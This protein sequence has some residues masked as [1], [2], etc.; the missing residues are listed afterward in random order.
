MADAARLATAPDIPIIPAGTAIKEA[1]KD[2]RL[3]PPPPPVRVTSMAQACMTLFLSVYV[4]CPVNLPLF[5]LRV[6]VN[7]VLVIVS[8]TGRVTELPVE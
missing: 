3:A 4:P 2:P 7:E 5:S 8:V 6:S 1:S